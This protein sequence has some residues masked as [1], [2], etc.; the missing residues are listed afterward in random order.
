MFLVNILLRL[1]INVTSFIKENSCSH[2]PRYKKYIEL[3][4]KCLLDDMYTKLT[5]KRIPYR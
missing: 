1:D 3:I 5:Y 2:K 4:Y